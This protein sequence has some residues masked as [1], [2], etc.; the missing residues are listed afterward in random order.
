MCV[1]ACVCVR[2]R[3]ACECFAILNNNT[4]AFTSCCV[5]HLSFLFFKFYFSETTSI[6]FRKS[7]FTDET[8]DETRETELPGVFPGMSRVTLV[9]GVMKMLRELS[10]LGYAPVPLFKK[11]ERIANMF[12]YGVR[13]RQGEC[14]TKSTISVIS[15]QA[16]ACR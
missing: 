4:L 13:W 1:R 3:R 2:V 15:K 7:V 9:F 16:S 11:K 5:R 10:F 8:S 14:C 12:V 6:P